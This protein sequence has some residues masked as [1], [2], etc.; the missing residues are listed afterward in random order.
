MREVPEIFMPNSS[1]NVLIEI[2]FEEHERFDI[3]WYHW[4]HDGT[5][6]YSWDRPC[7]LR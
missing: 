2:L 5:T 4:P 7:V 6:S 1:D 3:F